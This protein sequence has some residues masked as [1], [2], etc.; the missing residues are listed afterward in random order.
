MEIHLRADVVEE[1]TWLAENLVSSF[2]W[3]EK[4]NMTDAALER[5]LYRAGATELA[6]RVS[7]ARRHRGR[8]SA[9]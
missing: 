3:A 9:A 6:R 1:A 4:M 5:A 8:E 7:H 2:E